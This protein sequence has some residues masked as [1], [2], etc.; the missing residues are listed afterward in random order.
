MREGFESD[1]SYYP[2]RNRKGG[3][4]VSHTYACPRAFVL[5]IPCA[6]NI[7]LQISSWLFSSLALSLFL[8]IT[9]Q[10]NLPFLILLPY[11]VFLHTVYSYQAYIC[12]YPLSHFFFFLITALFQVPELELFVEWMSVF[13]S[14]VKITASLTFGQLYLPA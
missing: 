13:N 12:I 5:S 7:L 4:N 14:W 6:S 1:L 9:S 10:R 3:T 2:L 8:T 11:F